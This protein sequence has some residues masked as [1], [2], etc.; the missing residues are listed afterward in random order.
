MAVEAINDAAG[1]DGLVPTLLVF[2]AY[3]RKTN[4]DPPAP[5][6]LQRASAIKSAMKEVQKCHA[7]RQVNDALRISNGPHTSHLKGLPLNSKVIVY[8]EN[9]GW[10]GSHMM[11]SMSGETCTVM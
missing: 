7:W 5:S 10:T 4:L 6:V 3:P 8:R 2:G 9:G 11:T 1:P